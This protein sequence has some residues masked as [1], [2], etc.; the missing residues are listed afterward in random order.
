MFSASLAASGSVSTT[1]GPL[2]NA[3]SATGSDRLVERLAVVLDLDLHRRA[4]EAGRLEG[5][6]LPHGALLASAG[7]GTE[8]LLRPGTSRRAF[9]HTPRGSR[10]G[11]SPTRWTRSP[12]WRRSR[13]GSAPRWCATAASRWSPPTRPR[14]STAPPPGTPWPVPPSRRP[15]RAAMAGG[16]IGLLA[17]DLGGTVERL[18]APRPDPGGPPRRRAGPLRHRRADRRRRPLHGR[19]GRRRARARRPRRGGRGRAAARARCRPPVA[20]AG[21]DLAARRGL[22]RGRR[23]GA[24]ADPGRRLLP[25]EPGAAAD[26]ALGR[27]APRARAA[28]LE[29][30]R[31]RPRGAPTSRCPRA[32]WPRPRPSCW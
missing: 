10:S 16:W 17:Y 1:F 27:A 7:C 13:A 31:A 20:R 18:P 24:R 3:S 23:G 26:R 11:P 30:R 28:P 25:G 14:S 19:L 22:P 2:S 9:S 15:P 6:R 4:V 29:R 21:G 32:P 12:R 5:D 8:R